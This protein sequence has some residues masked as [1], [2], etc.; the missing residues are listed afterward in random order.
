MAG[1]VHN[2][3]R[4]GPAWDETL[5]VITFDE[6][7]GIFDHVP[8]PY[9][10]N[11]WPNDVN[12]GFRYNIL[13]PR[14]PTLLVSPWI[15]EQTVFRSPTD[16]A[17]DSTSILA[18]LLH[19]FGI[20][21]MRWGLGERVARAPTFEGALLRER[22][23]RDS[24]AFT[25]PWDR[26]FPRMGGG[27]PDVALNDLHRLMLP[28]LLWALGGGRADARLPTRGRSHAGAL[29]RPSGPAP[30]YPG[31]HRRVVARTSQVARGQ[32]KS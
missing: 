17:Y 31:L 21:T 15:R 1:V 3:L 16:V 25:P 4:S 5:L 26:D 11:P 23:R 10:R 19:W 27:H 30:P 18:T 20:P 6:H 24:P 7:G 12:D 22:P 28:R 32:G 29:T 9:A 14:V 2:A 8:P 13:G